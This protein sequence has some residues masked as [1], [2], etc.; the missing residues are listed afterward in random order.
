MA[1]WWGPGASV[2]LRSATTSGK[3]AAHLSPPLLLFAWRNK[4]LLL[5]M[6]THRE[7]IIQHTCS[8]FLA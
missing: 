8:P 6:M 7:H 5:F 2:R 1:G 4:S 3:A